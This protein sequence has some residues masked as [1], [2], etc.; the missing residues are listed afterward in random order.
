MPISPTYP[1]VYIEE[2]ASGVRTIV[3]VSTSDTAFVDFFAR[4]PMNETVRVTSFDDFE[5]KFGGLH[6]DSEASYA[7]QQ[8]Y[9]NAGQIAW[10]VRV[11]GGSPA[12]AQTSLLG[13]SPLQT[14]L[15]VKAANEGLWGES[16]QVA[17]DWIT[18]E[19][20]QF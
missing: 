6:R 1:G 16:V 2:V 5:R 13:G 20:E 7:I 9:L 17:V 14:A 8:F 12:A 11:A 10:V 18:R 4:G 19:P 15:T 3:G